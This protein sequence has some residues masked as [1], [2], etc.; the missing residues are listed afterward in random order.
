MV[1]CCLSSKVGC[2][3]EVEV[4]GI[5]STFQDRWEE[6][7]SYLNLCFSHIQKSVLSSNHWTTCLSLFCSFWWLYPWVGDLCLWE[8]ARPSKATGSGSREQWILEKVVFILAAC[9]SMPPVKDSY[10]SLHLWRRSIA[11]SPLGAPGQNWNFRSRTGIFFLKSTVT[12]S[13][14]AWYGSFMCSE[15]CHMANVNTLPFMFHFKVSKKNLGWQWY[16]KK[17]IT[18]SHKRLKTKGFRTSIVNE[19]EFHCVLQLPSVRRSR[20]S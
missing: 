17:I 2:H 18:E 1:P 6:R 5:F 15:G 8:M 20:C 4:V 12:A 10:T 11:F 9:I 3:G 16:V 7:Q 13:V 14:P 19:E